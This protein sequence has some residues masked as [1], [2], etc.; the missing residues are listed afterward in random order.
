MDKILFQKNYDSESIVDVFRDISESFDPDFNPNAVN[1]KK[2]DAVFV[3]FYFQD[4]EEKQDLL[5]R[6]YSEESL[7]DIEGNISDAL[8]DISV[9]QDEYGFFEGNLIVEMTIQNH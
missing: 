1:L 7:A 3:H 4:G 2:T 6:A 8:S 9:E 5:Q